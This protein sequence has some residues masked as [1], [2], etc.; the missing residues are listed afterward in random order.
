MTMRSGLYCWPA[1]FQRIGK[2]LMWSLTQFATVSSPSTMFATRRCGSLICPR[3]YE[4]RSKDHS[5]QLAPQVFQ[6]KL[7]GSRT[8]VV[9]SRRT[10]EFGPLYAVRT[11]DDACTDER[12]AQLTVG[13]RRESGPEFSEG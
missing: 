5:Y 3:W 2:S 10:N 11:G 4:G 8:D 1:E 6:G 12:S 9:R 13:V 7:C